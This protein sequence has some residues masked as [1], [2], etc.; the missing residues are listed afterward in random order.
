MLAQA[1][2]GS[3]RVGRVAQEAVPGIVARGEGGSE[4]G[5][6]VPHPSPF[7]GVTEE[8][9]DVVPFCSG[10][11]EALG[12]IEEDALRGEEGQGEAP[13]SAGLWL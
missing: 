1:A 2:S 5:H 11:L 12:P 8:P 10:G 9:H 7:D 4:G 6:G 3:S 13:C